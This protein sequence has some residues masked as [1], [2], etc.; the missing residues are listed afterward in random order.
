[1]KEYILLFSQPSTPF[2]FDHVVFESL[3]YPRVSKN[4]SL[5]CAR[6]QVDYDVQPSLR[7]LIFF[8]LQTDDS[9]R[10]RKRLLDRSECLIY[11]SL[12]TEA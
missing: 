7:T 2:L 8:A 4:F 12:L 3:K 5:T 10:E 11:N 6:A 1:M 9:L